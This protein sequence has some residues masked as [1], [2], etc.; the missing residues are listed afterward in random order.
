MVAKI[1]AQAGA[2]I[3]MDAVDKPRQISTKSGA[4][5]DAADSLS[6]S[7]APHPGGRQLLYATPLGVTDIVTETDKRSEEAILA[8]IQKAFPD[9]AILGECLGSH[10]AAPTWWRARH[11]G[12]VF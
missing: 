10:T 2:T 9:H 4:H 8:H 11:P 12:R 3:V 6:P 1:A 7:S 5:C